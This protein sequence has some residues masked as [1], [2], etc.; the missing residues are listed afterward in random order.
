M[1]TLRQ[2]PSELVGRAVDDVATPVDEY[3]EFPEDVLNLS[4]FS[5]V[6]GS[7]QLKTIQ[8]S[9]VAAKRLSADGSDMHWLGKAASLACGR[10]N[11]K[12]A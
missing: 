7:L 10:P 6:H 3:V 8:V 5:R 12:K 11:N 2:V 4:H 1:C 9:R